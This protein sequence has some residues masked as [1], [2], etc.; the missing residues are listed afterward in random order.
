MPIFEV[1]NEGMGEVSGR[2]SDRSSWHTVRF[3]ISLIYTFW[4]NYGIDNQIQTHR[5]VW[6]GFCD[7]EFI[8]ITVSA[9]EVIDEGERMANWTAIND[10]VKND[11]FEKRKFI[12]SPGV[13]LR[14]GDFQN[15]MI[16]FASICL[17]LVLV[18]SLSLSLL[19]KN[20]QGISVNRG[21]RHVQS[22]RFISR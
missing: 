17:L 19:N 8:A 13:S 5:C 14:P 18:P 21:Y 4:M 20:S 6:T 3:D 9:D 22:L 1:P 15:S 12:I 10:L 16:C 11:A 7:D 2:P